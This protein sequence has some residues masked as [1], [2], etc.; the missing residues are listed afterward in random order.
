MNGEHDAL[1]PDGVL[2]TTL[3]VPDAWL[4]GSGRLR[5]AFCLKAFDDAGDALTE[6]AGM[7]EAYTRQT[8]NSWVALESHLAYHA[9]AC[10]G[11]SL[12]IESCVLDLDAKKIHVFQAMY[13]ESELLATHEQ[14][15]LHFNP[16]SR[17]G[18]PFEP[19][20][21]AALEALCA[22]RAASPRPPQAGRRVV[23]A[24]DA[25]GAYS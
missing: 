8:H 9:P 18:C 20:V 12:R 14:L 16:A 1:P 4:D 21:H 11:D 23:L 6:L 7:G 17:R 19:A 24:G 25:A 3:T 22:A 10:R 15:G 2:R 13:R 5:E